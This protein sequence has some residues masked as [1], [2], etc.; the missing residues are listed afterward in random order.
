MWTL[1]NILLKLSTFQESRNPYKSDRFW[2]LHLNL[3]TLW[4]KAEHHV[5]MSWLGH[6][7]LKEQTEKW[8][9]IYF[10]PGEINQDKSAF[11]TTHI[12]DRFNVR[13]Y[14]RPDMAH[15]TWWSCNTLQT[16]LNE[17]TITEIVIFL[18]TS[19]SRIAKEQSSKSQ[20]LMTTDR[21]ILHDETRHFTMKMK[22]S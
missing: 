1:W 19:F 6:I 11:A 4:D 2:S 22:T 20:C 18:Y 5:I 16:A 10:I 3:V 21:S 9:K 14:K 13:C 8:S 15:I 17:D 7:D 12:Y